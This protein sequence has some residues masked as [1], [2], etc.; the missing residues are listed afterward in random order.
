MRRRT[1]GAAAAL[2]ALLALT[3]CNGGE[4]TT[5]EPTSTPTPTE[6]TSAPTDPKDQAVD[7]ATAALQ[8]YFDVT[9]E[10]RNNPQLPL[11]RLETVAIS[12][13]LL[14][15]Q[16]EF[17]LYREE[18]GITRTGDATFEVQKVLEISLDNSNPEKGQ[19]PTVKLQVCWDRSKTDAV[20]QN[21][22]SQVNPDRIDR[23]KATFFVSNY[24][25]AKKPREGWKVSSYQTPGE[26][27]C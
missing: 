6:T 10:L 4:P 3:A 2:T 18:K 7:D 17:R 22:E 13:G 5:T 1:A 25:F 15:T 16:Q 21:G 8:R 23:S 24:N 19:V 14:Y 11:K 12:S 27:E 26:E 9:N 20:D